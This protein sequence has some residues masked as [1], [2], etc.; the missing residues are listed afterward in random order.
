MA[1]LHVKICILI[2][3]PAVPPDEA[4]FF[5][6]IEVMDGLRG[7]AVAPPGSDGGSLRSHK[8]QSWLATGC[9][10][11]GWASWPPPEN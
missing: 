2:I 3:W 4:P 11:E 1:G 6:A 9:G 7:R 10:V 5:R 8:E